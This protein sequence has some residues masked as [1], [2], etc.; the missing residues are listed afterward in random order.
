MCAKNG[1]G[2]C[3][4][5][6]CRYLVFALFAVSHFGFMFRR[7]DSRFLLPSYRFFLFSLERLVVENVRENVTAH[8][9]NAEHHH[10]GITH[11]TY[12]RVK[13]KM[14]RT[15]GRF[16]RMLAN[17]VQI[18]VSEV[19]IAKLTEKTLRHIR[20][21]RN[22]TIPAVTLKPQIGCRLFPQNLQRKCRN[23]VT[24]RIS[25]DTHMSR[26]HYQQTGR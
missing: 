21:T 25:F 12:A 14:N 17:S 18:L 9:F 6:T 2:Y 8:P 4:F 19:A 20:S 7:L 24:V 3:N 16:F 26:R 22:I 10:T 15:D 5:A 11:C 23:K 1:L 13:L